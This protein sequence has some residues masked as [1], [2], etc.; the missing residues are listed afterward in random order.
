MN[1]ETNLD[2]ALE[3]IRNGEFVLVFDDDDREGEVDMIIDVE[4][5]D[6]ERIR[7]SE[8]LALA[9][10]EGLRMAFFALNTENPMFSDVR[11]R[12]A[13]NGLLDKEAIVE[14]AVNGQGV[15]SISMD[16]SPYPGVVEDN[17]VV[18]DVDAALAL[19]EEAQVDPKTMKF[20]VICFDGNSENLTN[21]VTTV[22]GNTVT[23]GGHEKNFN[24]KNSNVGTYSIGRKTEAFAYG[25][26]RSGSTLS[27]V[28][29][30]CDD[31]I[32]WA[33]MD[34]TNILSSDPNYT[35]NAASTVNF[36]PSLV[37]YNGLYAE[38][39]GKRTEYLYSTPYESASVGRLTVEQARALGERYVYLEANESF[40]LD[41]SEGGVISY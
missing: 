30:D 10:V 21:K 41:Y 33:V 31:I 13:I 28:Y 40:A 34:F 23:R 20:T 14:V 9:E 38:S 3:A 39:G 11:V 7:E 26:N 6:V 12:R 5:N 22:N 17:A 25:A 35:V 15:P 24:V 37:P 16:P 36:I 18:H 32:S 2:K 8:N 29:A 19:F 1:Q 27:Q 4:S